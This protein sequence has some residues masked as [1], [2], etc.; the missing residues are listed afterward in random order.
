MQKYLLFLFLLLQTGVF[1]QALTL[2]RVKACIDTYSA[3]YPAEKMYMQFDKPAYSAGE[4]IWF[5]AYLMKGFE[6]SNISR[7]LYVDFSDT[8]GNILMHGVYPIQRSSAAGSFE[9]SSFFKGK[10]VHVRAYTKWMMNFDTSF[11]YDR[12]IRILQKLQP[13]A[14]PVVKPA[15]AASIQ[16]FPESGDYIV[17]VPNRIAFKANYLNG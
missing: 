14:K 11:L 1:A 4:T 2:Q 9:L 13:N 3:L 10:N 12:D 16:F 7:S 5:K 6:V 15:L 8:A 17:G